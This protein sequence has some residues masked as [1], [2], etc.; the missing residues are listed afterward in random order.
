MKISYITNLRIPSIKANGIQVMHNCEAFKKTGANICLYI[1]LRFKSK[2]EPSFPDVF[3]YYSVDS[4]FPIEKV[5][6]LDI[7]PLAD[8][9]HAFRHFAFFLQSVSFYFFVLLKFLFIKTEV[10]YTR[11]AWLGLALFYKKRK[12]LELHDFPQKKLGGSIYQFL[13]KRF[14]KVIVISNGLKKEVSK[15]T[16]S[17]NILL[18]PDGVKTSMFDLKLDTDSARQKVGII[19]RKKIVMYSGSLQLWKGVGLLIKAFTKLPDYILHIV[20]ST[21][22]PED[23]NDIKPCENVIS[24][25]HVAYKDIPYYLKSADVLVIPNSKES[26]IS[27]SYTSPLKAFEYMASGK[28]IVVSNL[29]SMMEV[30]N[31]KNAYVFNAEDEN[32]LISKI[33]EALSDSSRAQQSY[34]DSKRYSWDTRVDQIIDFIN[35]DKR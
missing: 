19:S 17:K 29:P 23:L 13:I 7:F 5:F 6:S 30:F 35:E 31:D 9:A 24:V 33:T 11:D 2:K 27:V 28:P 32:D 21:L 20:G 18:A 10:I 1:P 26:V 3:D 25:G 12:I 4:R 14:T 34:L 22:D 16:D 8:C 15:F